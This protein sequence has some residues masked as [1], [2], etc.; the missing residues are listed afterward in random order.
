[1]GFPETRP[2][3]VLYFRAAAFA[4]LGALPIILA[5]CL[6]GT[7]P[8]KE[9]PANELSVAL[10]LTPGTYSLQA[11]H[12]GKCVDVAAAGTADG[13]KLQQWGC[14]GKANQQ[15]ALKDLGSG[16][17]EVRAVH[18]G[19]CAD[20]AGWSTANGG[21]I[22]QWTCRGQANQKWRIADMG[23][24]QYQFK[25]VHSGKCLDVKG[26]STADGAAIH[27]WTCYNVGQQKFKLIPAA[28]DGGGGGGGSVTWRQ[29]N[30]T[31]FTSYPDP[32]SEECIVYNGCTW[33]GYF[34][35]VSGKQ[36][37]SWVKANNIIAVHEKHFAAYKLKT[38]RIK[39]GTRQIDAKVYDMCSD[40]DCDGCCTR[41]LGSAGFLID[42]EKYTK[43]RFGSGSG[44][45]D[46]TCIDCH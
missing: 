28:I 3:P 40:S 16:V 39:Q 22:H 2:R 45:V 43:E 37:E 26:I 13:A 27:Q 23:D 17:F 33:A 24:G 34:A 19:K 41:N 7:E 14:N 10:A 31:W 35:G 9:S 18:S 6:G 42:M 29:A 30:L 4:A 46:W 21:A 32:G 36:P 44:T 38:F 12:S 11:V 25:S 15:F 20:V 8:G 5:A 1:M